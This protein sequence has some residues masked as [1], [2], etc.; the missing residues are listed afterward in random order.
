V[1]LRTLFFLISLSAVAVLLGV[2]KYYFLP[3]YLVSRVASEVISSP[4]PSPLSAKDL[5]QQN[6]EQVEAIFQAMSPDQRITQAL[7]FPVQLSSSS[8]TQ[9]GRLAGSLDWISER[10]PGFVMI[11]GQSVSTQSALHFTTA[12]RQGV[13]SQSAVLPSFAADHEGGRVQR[14]NGTGFTKL[15]SAEELCESN[16]QRRRSLYQQSAQELSAAG[17]QIVFAPVIDLRLRASPS[18]VASPSG[19][20]NASAL[21]DRICSDDPQT[22]E[23]NAR[24]WITTFEQAG[25]AS[26]I[27]HYPGIGTSQLDLHREREAVSTPEEERKLFT[28]LLE[29]F[30]LLSVMSTHVLVPQSSPDSL[31]QAC[32]LSKECLGELSLSP[33]Q[34]LFTDAL[35][36][37]A[38]QAATSSKK[39]LSQL[40]REA[41]EA[42][43]TV[44]V[45][46]ADTSVSELE[47]VREVL[48]RR[49]LVSDEFRQQLD[50]SV[51]KILYFKLRTKSLSAP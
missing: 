10:N 30:P 9:S 23:E 38:A 49:Y 16:T 27:K 31:P 47:E 18:A 8:S 29:V 34:L 48:V 17:L 14:L 19:S 1:K 3:R 7:V 20:L 13:T 25:V 50:Q 39:P 45:F 41:I 11:F 44:L 4:A 2:G 42:G 36:M 32:S 15:P 43:N 5:D 22:V 6:I 46:G 35:D 26:V 21:G 12:V 24:L 33:P 37:E 40:S 28:R 51:R